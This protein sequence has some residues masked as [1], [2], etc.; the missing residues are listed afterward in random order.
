[1]F[2][3]YHGAHM[4]PS[5]QVAFDLLCQ[6]MGVTDVTVEEEFD[7]HGFW[8]G[9]GVRD[10]WIELF[11]MA[12]GQ[13]LISVAVDGS[14]AEHRVLVSEDRGWKRFASEPTPPGYYIAQEKIRHHLVGANYTTGV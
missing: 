7:W 12:S 2:N 6:L 1:M 4:S 14:G 13:S 3:Y 9:V 10:C 5:Q 8:V 11:D